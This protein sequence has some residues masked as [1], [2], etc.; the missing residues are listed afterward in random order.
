MEQV[1]G[2]HLSLLQQRSGCTLAVV[3]DMSQ[4]IATQKCLWDLPS[5][6]TALR[7]AEGAWGSSDQ[8]VEAASVYII[9]LFH[10]T[11]VAW[12]DV[13]YTNITSLTE[14]SI[15][16]P[17]PQSPFKFPE[18]CNYPQKTFPDKAYSA[19]VFSRMKFVLFCIFHF[20]KLGRPYSGN[21]R[22]VYKGQPWTTHLFPFALHLLFF[23]SSSWILGPIFQFD[24]GMPFFVSTPLLSSLDSTFCFRPFGLE[25]LAQFSIVLTPLVWC[26][27][28]T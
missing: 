16:V 8:L 18:V 4:W 26:L 1:G 17:P 9:Q 2:R 15:F 11:T 23:L 3:S 14:N 27:I 21:P 22:R 7:N 5:P 25:L 19:L 10:Q 28:L 6:H 13:C 12:R 20:F 24:V